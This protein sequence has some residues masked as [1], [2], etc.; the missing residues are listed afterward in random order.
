MDDVLPENRLAKVARLLTL[1][2]EELRDL[3]ADPTVPRSER[4][5]CRRTRDDLQTAL[6]RLATAQ[7]HVAEL[8]AEEAR[9]RIPA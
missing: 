3:I 6:A 1:S 8:R 5:R 2:V 9:E 7:R 4:S